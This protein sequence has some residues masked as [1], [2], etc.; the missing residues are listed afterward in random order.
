MGFLRLSRG[1]KYLTIELPNTIPIMALG[2]LYQYF[3]PL[4]NVA[5][6]TSLN[7]TLLFEVG[8]PVR[9]PKSVGTVGALSSAFFV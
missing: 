8:S 6:C 3:D 4:D 2:T 5:C 9:R 7:E 1:L